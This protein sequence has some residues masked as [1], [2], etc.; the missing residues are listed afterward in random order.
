MKISTVLIN[1]K[2]EA[3]EAVDPEKH[4][5]IGFFRYPQIYSGQEFEHW[6]RGYWDVPQYVTIKVAENR[7]S[8]A[9]LRDAIEAAWK[10]ISRTCSF[11]ASYQWTVEHYHA[12]LREQERRAKI[13]P[14]DV[15]SIHGPVAEQARELP[16]DSLVEAPCA[17][18]PASVAAATFSTG[19]AGLTVSGG[20]HL[21]ITVGDGKRGL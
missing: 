17:S 7:L 12:L 21:N 1:G 3:P 10:L 9:E 16:V 11:E 8:N 6:Q 15:S 2:L 19:S 4:Q 5:F 14:S 18:R 20:D 13:I